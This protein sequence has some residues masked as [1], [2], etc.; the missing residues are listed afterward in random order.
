MG[1]D[2]SLD[3]IL[4]EFRDTLFQLSKD[5][6]TAVLGPGG[7]F[8]LAVSVDNEPGVVSLPCS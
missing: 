8:V 7:L 6:I 4:F 1:K 2:I 3:N 5:Q